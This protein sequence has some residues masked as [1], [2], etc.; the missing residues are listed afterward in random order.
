MSTR[1]LILSSMILVVCGLASGH[2]GETQ[3]IVVL[4]VTPK[5]QDAPVLAQ[6]CP[7]GVC[8]PALIDLTPRTPP[9]VRMIYG[10]R[11]QIREFRSFGSR[12]PLRTFLSRF[13]GRR[14]C[15]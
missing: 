1:R 6:D 5:V 2:A 9:R 15:N 8:R 7:G 12:R 3:D 11:T 13:S 4:D 10:T 14:C